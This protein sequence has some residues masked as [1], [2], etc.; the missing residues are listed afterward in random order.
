LLLLGYKFNGVRRLVQV[1]QR[2]TELKAALALLHPK[3]EEERLVAFLDD[4][5]HD[6]MQRRAKI[7]E[8]AAP[9]GLAYSTMENGAI[10]TCLGM[11]RLFEGSSLRLT[12]S[13]TKYDAASRRLYGHAVV[14]VRADPLAIVAYMLCYD[15]RTMQ[16]ANAANPRMVRF[17]VVATVN[18]KHTIV[19]TRYTA[20]GMKDRTFLNAF[21]AKQVAEHPPTFAVAIVPIPRHD[22][23][24]QEDE[25][26]AVRAE[27]YRSFRLTAVAPGVSRLEYCCSLDLR[28]RVP[29]WVTDKV[30]T[31]AQMKVTAPLWRR[32]LLAQRPR[33][34]VYARD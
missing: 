34:P 16:S 10:E 11:F 1:N 17:E 28:G 19:F 18:A 32:C 9:S 22:K 30:A 27:N 3:M 23:I 13:Q 29:Q 31:P 14:E 4:V 20:P 15:S 24:G 12:R 26:G 7:N 33:I 6:T 2:R 25:A 21:V 8:L 5:H